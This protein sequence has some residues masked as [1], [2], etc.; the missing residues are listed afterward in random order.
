MS[1]QWAKPSNARGVGRGRRLLHD[2][3]M[4][5]EKGRLITQQEMAL[6]TPVVV[7]GEESRTLLPA[8]SIRSAVSCKVA[9]LPYTVVGVAEAGQRLRACRSTASSIAP[10]RSPLRHVVNRRRSSTR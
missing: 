9:G 2:Q 1:S 4:K 8:I 10:Y 5:V 3:E 6:G 7:I